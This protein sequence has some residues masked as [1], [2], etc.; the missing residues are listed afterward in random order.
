MDYSS[1][2]P[3][4]F[5]PMHNWEY[6]VMSSAMPTS[7]PRPQWYGPPPSRRP[8]TRAGHTRANSYSQHPGMTP[9]SFDSPRFGSLGD[10]ATVDVSAKNI[11]PPLRTSAP[12][13]PT[14][15]KR[16]RRQS[17]TYVRASTPYGES[18]EDETVEAMGRT[19][20]LPAQSRFRSCQTPR[21]AMYDGGWYTNQGAHPQRSSNFADAAYA[22]SSP[23]DLPQQPTTPKT[24][25]PTSH[26]HKRRSSTAV[27]QRSST[28]RPSAPSHRPK[29]KA[30]HVKA[31][32]EDA[33][34]HQIPKGYHLKNWDPKEEPILLLGS[35]FDVHT[36]GNWIYD[37]AVVA[38]E[39]NSP[40]AE[41]SSELWL[42]LINLAGRMALIREVAGRVRTSENRRILK[43]F[44]DAGERIMDNLRSH[45]EE[46]E[47]FM[48]RAARKKGSR[49]GKTMGIE[50]VNIL[51]GRD[52]AL[53]ETDKFMQSIRVFHLRFDANCEEII[54]NP[55]A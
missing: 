20:V 23:H 42:L 26:R 11:P 44:S 37:W 46:C 48:P 12:H 40:I 33:K 5:S 50:F 2:Q 19:Y 53:D 31:T 27:P 47:E 14:C 1:P 34:R 36:L 30:P 7:C 29:P 51:F 16:D 15:S 49:L 39:S 21:P 18:D 22:R 43:E 4:G 3:A 55:F 17:Y 35:V 41:M 10:Y 13:Y 24:R 52:K 32:D 28:A 54:R 38:H 6:F 9:R 45:M 25:P 8:A